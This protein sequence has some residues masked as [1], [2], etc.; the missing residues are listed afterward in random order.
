MEKVAW[1]LVEGAGEIP[2]MQVEFRRVEDAYPGHLAEADGTLLG[3]P[4]YFVRMSG[5]MK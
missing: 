2:E 3:S 4:T 5:G 1:A